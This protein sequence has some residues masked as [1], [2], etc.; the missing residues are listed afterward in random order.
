MDRA[1]QWLFSQL[2]TLTDDFLRAN[3]EDELRE[4]AL[5]GVAAL[6][7]AGTL[8]AEAA[9]IWARRFT[10]DEPAPEADEHVRAAARDL[11]I[12]VVDD[13]ENDPE[14]A[15]RRFHP[16]LEV[17]TQAGAAD[18]DEWD[19]HLRERLG[20]PS[21]EEELALER[22]ANQGATE[23]ELLSVHAGP[24]DVHDG[25]RLLYVQLFADGVSVA[26]ET[27]EIEDDDDWDGF[28]WWLTDDRGT[29]YEPRG[30]GGGG[31]LHMRFS[32]RVPEGASWLEVGHEARGVRLR[33]QL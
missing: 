2:E 21:E 6:Q 18:Y 15:Q 25:S 29:R 19:T 16:M 8:D 1:E 28:E 20:W 22:E 11:L 26:L 33:V 3:G 13:A 32:P 7:A 9:R 14:T 30:G 12:R 10:E 24:V 31:T 23:V 4:R 5:A 17:L 27:P